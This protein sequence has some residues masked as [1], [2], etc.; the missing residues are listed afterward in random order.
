MIGFNSEEEAVQLAN[1]SRYGLAATAWTKDLSRA[2]R[3][4]RDLEAGEVTGCATTAQATNLWHALSVETVWPI[5]S[6]H[7]GWPTRFRGLSAQQSRADYYRLKA[8]T[9]EIFWS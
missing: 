3:L 9:L 4:T 1:G 7:S 8:D 2:R 6:W 5:R